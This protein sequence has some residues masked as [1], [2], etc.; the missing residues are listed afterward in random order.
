MDAGCVAEVMDA[1]TAGCVAGLKDALTAGCVAE[2]CVYI[3]TKALQWR[4]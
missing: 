2:L 3:C 1:L 4:I